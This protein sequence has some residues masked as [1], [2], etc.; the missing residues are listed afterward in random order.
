[1]GVRLT[2]ETQGFRGVL[3]VRRACADD[4]TEVKCAEAIDD[5]SRALVQAT[6]DPG[7]YF[8]VVDRDRAMVSCTQTLTGLWGS[9]VT[10]PGTGV[11][12][13]NAMN[14][15]D[16]TPGGPNEIRPWKRP[17]SRPEAPR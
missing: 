10:A 4:A 1:M 15:F 7:T 5:G 12:L 2:L 6:L 14:L 17:L 11:L 16:P 8:A 9:G 13:N 3:S